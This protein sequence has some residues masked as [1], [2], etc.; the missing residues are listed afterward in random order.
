MSQLIRYFLT[1][2]ITITIVSC[3]GSDKEIKATI[4]EKRTELEQKRKKQTELAAEIKKLE[5]ELALLDTATSKELNAKL[6][7]VTMLNSQEFKHFIEIQGKVIS[8]NISNISPRLGPGQVKAIYVKQGSNVRKGQLLLKLDDAVIR[9]QIV[10][11]RSSLGTI[12]AQLTS[13]K[14]VLNRYEN[15][16]KQGI[17][18]EVQL[19]EFRTKVNLLEAQL[20]AAREN[21]KIYDEQLRATNV[22]SDVNGVAE[23][24]NVR[25]GETFMGMMGAIPQIQIVNNSSLKVE[26]AIPENYAS[27][28]KVGSPVTVI[29]PDANKTYTSTISLS[30]KMI[31]ANNRSFNIEARI[32]SDGSSRPNQIAKIQ[33]QDYAVKNTIAVPVNTVQ[34]DEKGK[35][36]FVAV[37]EGDRMVARKKSV[38][39]GELNGEMI[40]IRVGLAV[41]EQLITEGY[42]N[43]YEGQVISIVK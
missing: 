28:V 18:S 3:G 31:D 4:T 22:Y 25:V 38:G 41:G 24:V 37:K 42:Q 27:R 23:Q 20:T 40:E 34:T 10:A 21:I 35:Y 16:R 6:V 13:A 19:I 7:S 33:I 32:P 30:G 26:A 39:V 29:L 17:G 36:V 2:F 1:F 5:D 11:A 9:Q 12:Q 43:L 15:L 8:D 14:D